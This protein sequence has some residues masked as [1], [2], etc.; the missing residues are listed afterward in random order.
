MRR[1]IWWQARLLPIIIRGRD[2]Q[3]VL[4]YAEIAPDPAFAGLP[5]EAIA[6]WV[7]A[8]TRR[9]WLMRDRRCLR[10][11]LLGMRFMRLAGH[12]P[13]LHFGIDPRSLSQPVLAAHCWIVL[14]GRP[15]LNDILDG[16]EPLYVWRPA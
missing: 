15:V 8:A 4:S 14:A 2:L 3:S 5:A 12:A 1:L 6:G 16:M 7:T 10:Q 11:G 9:P 13:E